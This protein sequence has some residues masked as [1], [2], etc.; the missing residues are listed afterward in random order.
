MTAVTIVD[1]FVPRS[2]SSDVALVSAGAVI[3]AIA[4]QVQI[5]MFPVPMTL[6]TFAVLLVAATLGAARGSL[7]LSLYLLLG[8]I[9][10]PV[11]AGAKTLTGVLPTT[12]YL[13]G[14]I[15]AAAV[16]GYLSSKGFS[17]SPIKLAFSFALGSTI[18]Y[19]L[20]VA[21]LMITLGLSFSQALAAGVAPFVIGDIVKALLAAAALP[22]AWKLIK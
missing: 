16:I 19:A 22:L 13:L 21:G 4:A 7:S 1:R 8:A 20:G 17:K 10:L 3:T 14:F 12:G 15:A 18:I 11:F 2:I 9:G 5:P 6:Q